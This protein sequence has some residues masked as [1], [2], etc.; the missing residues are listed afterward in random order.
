MALKVSKGKADELFNFTPMIDVVFN[1]LLFFMV[2][3][4]FAQEEREV[5]VQLPSASEARPLTA[6]PTELFVNVNQVGQ[7]FAGNREVTPAELD[8]YLQQ[9]A[10]NNP[11]NQTVIIRADK[12]VPFDHVVTVMNACNK[13]KLFDYKITS[14]NE[15]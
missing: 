10:V 12:R 1:L 6:T 13:A 5:P 14:A 15:E 9:A 3:A 4:R 7:I 11:A 2:A 8:T